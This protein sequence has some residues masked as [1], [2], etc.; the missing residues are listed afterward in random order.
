MVPE[1][2]ET[3]EVNIYGFLL[4]A[5]SCC[6]VGNWSPIGE[7]LLLGWKSRDQNSRQWKSLE[8]FMVLGRREL[9][10]W[11]FQNSVW[12]SPYVLGWR[13]GW[14]FAGQDSRKSCRDQLLQG[15]ELTGETGSCVALRNIKALVHAE[16][17]DLSEYLGHSVENPKR[18]HFWNKNH[19][20]E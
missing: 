6:K 2:R 16:W 7:A 10:K 20:W 8:F 3:H 1:R 11:V 17:G 12:D 4:G 15:W 19:I 5:F 18:P 9:Q 13:L 14:D